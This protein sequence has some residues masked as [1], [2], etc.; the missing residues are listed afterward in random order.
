[1]I[2]AFLAAPPLLSRA[3]AAVEA[4]VPAAQPGKISHRARAPKK[5]AAAQPAAQ[6]AAQPVP[7]P[8]PPA[9]K[10]PNWPANDP[11]APASVVWDSHG[12]S[13]VASNSSLAQILKEVSVDTGVKIEGFTSDERIF[14]S[15]GPAPASNVLS[16]LLDGS[17]Y[18]VLIVGD[19]GQGTPR[20]VVLTPHSNSAPSNNSAAPAKPTEEDNAVEE[21]SQQQPDE[22]PA[23]PPQAQPNAYAPDVPMRTQQ[24]L[25]QEMQQRERQLEQQRQQQQNP[26]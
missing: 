1:V 21:Q 24:Q 3:N 7:P 26:Q 22:Q 11:P 19:Q 8:A 13:V 9:P 12:L 20:R 23:P 18:D 6:A 15:Y 14:G 25:I 2:A 16:Q 5:P 17:T 10:P 4:Q